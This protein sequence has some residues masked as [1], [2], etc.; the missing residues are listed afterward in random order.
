MFI[1]IGGGKG[2]VGKTFV[3]ANLGIA[4]S[5]L[6]PRYNLKITIVDTDIGGSNLHSFLGIAKPKKTLAD[7][8]KSSDIEISDVLE[9]TQFPGISAVCGADDLLNLVNLSYQQKIKLLRGFNDIDADFI[10]FDL[11]A[12]TELKTLDFFNFAPLGIIVTTPEPTAMQN[13]Y[14]FIRNALLRK[15]LA[16]SAD[17]PVLKDLVDSFVEGSLDGIKSIRSFLDRVEDADPKYLEK[18]HSIIKTFQP[19][20]ILNQTEERSDADTAKKFAELIEKYL[21]VK[22]EILGWLPYDLRVRE[23]V[24]SGE[25][26][27]D[28]FRR[29]RTSVHLYSI[30]NLI[31]RMKHSNAG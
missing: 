7:F 9:P 3:S 26:F 13:A 27:M 24:K 31:L 25:I 8:I 20:L 23:A 30:A 16:K 29:S 4:L 15:I 18:I 28:I 5:T 22:L 14:S 11:A 6:D 17:N 2:G 21:F 12:G 1:S 19:K 10:L